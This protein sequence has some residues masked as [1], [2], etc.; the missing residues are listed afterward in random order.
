M[1]YEKAKI[2]Y[3]KNGGST[4]Y[5]EVMFNP[6]EYNLSRSVTY[7]EQNIPGTDS[8]VTQYINGSSDTLSLT[9]FFDTYTAVSAVKGII[10]PQPEKDIKPVTN[11][12]NE[13]YKLTNI[14]GT[15]HRPPICTFKWGNLNFTGVITDIKQNFIMFLSNGMPVR[16]KLDVTFKSVTDEKNKRKASPFESPDRT[17]YCPVYEKT[18]LWYMAYSEYGD[19]NCW[20]K[21]AQANNL[22]NPLDLE[23]GM[24]LTL[25]AL[26]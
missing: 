5:T 20:R 22:L 21:I 25:P 13:I 1:A 24:M 23:S 15:L 8:P 26:T 17:K 6:A 12:T 11:K 10:K 2:Y 9:L 4:A 3:E 7:N 18:H 14:D 16:A 19:C